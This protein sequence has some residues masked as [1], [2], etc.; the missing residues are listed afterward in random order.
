[1]EKEA[2]QDCHIHQACTI[3]W[4]WERPHQVFSLGPEKRCCHIIWSYEKTDF[5]PVKQKIL[6]HGRE[7]GEHLVLAFCNLF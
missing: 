3:V 4:L 6:I 2:V 5:L 7:R 1:M